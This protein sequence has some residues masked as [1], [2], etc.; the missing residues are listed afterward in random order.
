M[1]ETEELT[2]DEIE[3]LNKYLSTVPKKEEKAG[4]FSFFQRVFKA[5]D[6]SKAG[7]VDEQELFSARTY[8]SAALYADEMNLKEVGKYLRNEGEIVLATSLS[9]TGFLIKAIIT[10]KRELTAKTAA[11]KKKRWLGKK[12]ETEVT[13]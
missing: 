3:E 8:Q 10:Q 5:K 13:T 12:E 9:K 6:T 4:I 1:D 2:P 7:F 11:E